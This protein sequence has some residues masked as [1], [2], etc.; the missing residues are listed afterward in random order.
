MIKILDFMFRKYLGISVENGKVKATEG[1][2]G[3]VKFY[4]SFSSLKVGLIP[5]VS[6][7]IERNENFSG[8]NEAEDN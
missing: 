3:I 6:K 8:I 2:T 7:I 4:Y 1:G 5:L